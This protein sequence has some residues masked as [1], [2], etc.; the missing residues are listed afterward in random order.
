MTGCGRN[1]PCPCGSGKKYK[2]CCLA[3]NSGKS[4]AM[5]REEVRLQSALQGAIEHHQCG[6]LAEAEAGYRQILQAAPRHADALHL[7]GIVAQQRG[8]TEDAVRLIDSAIKA[9]PTQPVYYSNLGNILREQGR[10]VEATTLYRQALALQADL[11]D[12]H[13]SLAAALKDQGRLDEAAQSYCRAV[14]LKPG[15]AEAY[16]NLGTVFKEQGRFDQAGASYAQ[17]LSL[18]A[19]FAEVHYNLGN[20]LREQGSLARAGAS[21]ALAL[22]L[23]PDFAAVYCNL[24]T[25]L[26]DQGKLPEA[27]TAYAQA[28]LLK[29]DYADA[30]C[31]LGNVQRDQGQLDE[32]VASYRQA[33]WLQPA[34]LE[35]GNNLGNA[36]RQLGQFDEAI[37]VLL[38]A[39]RRAE[40]VDTKIAFAQGIKGLRLTG[41][42]PDI[43]TAVT[44]ALTEAWI[45]PAE[46][47]T[48]AMSLIRLD[49]DIGESIARAQSAWPRRLPA[50]EL[51][52]AQGLPALASELLLHSLLHSTPIRDLDF[53][54]FLTLARHALLEA[55]LDETGTMATGDAASNSL[56]EDSL[57]FYCALARQC[58]I[59]EYVF[60]LTDD[61][62]DKVE[63]LRS[64]LIEALA[65]RSPVP[66]LTLVA[67]AAYFPLHS[68]PQAHELQRLVWPD[69]VAAVLLQQLQEPAEEWQRRAR[70]PR[71]TPIGGSVSLQV[72]EQYEENPYPRWVKAPL[73]DK[74]KSV[75]VFLHHNFPASRFQAYGECSGVDILI[76]GC[77]TG[78]HAIKTA[79]QFS[80]ARLLAID[81]SLTSLCYAKRM[82]DALGLKNI[83]YAQADIMELGALGRSF[84]IIESVGVLHHLADPVAGW[85]VLLDLLRPGGF[86]DIG[87]YSALARRQ[88]VVARR[89][90]AE[91]GYAATAADIRRCRQDLMTLGGHEELLSFGDFFAMSDCRDLLFHVQEQR[92]TL[93]QLK[94]ILQTLGLGLVGFRL[95]ASVARQYAERFGSDPTRTD[96]DHWHQFET[97]HPRTFAAM[98]Q[99]WVQKPR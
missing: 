25:V 1:K 20:L 40:N 75:D 48:P 84:D 69:A 90:I 15:Y 56:T 78:Q 80:G 28:L 97:E 87:L 86:M 95:E 47:L 3:R 72:Q 5:K 83:E 54:R 37:S 74:P 22:A 94:D 77:G 6:R 41:A 14:S 60:A 98:Y 50:Q 30:H 63:R 27:A 64:R 36:L 29:P 39:L 18:Q 58:F 96:L 51:F 21:Y 19:D 49:P 8:N 68:L 53:E 31:N 92:Y 33:L 43:R 59:N 81:L 71:L 2:H 26:K 13:F 99:F 88:I 67:V 34:L 32:A 23:K 91:R 89:H 93:P 66:V 70:M 4:D 73:G 7:L 9:K 11:A 85:R 17:A 82:T 24:G 44:R 16:C 42:N 12:V 52:G 38:G 55:A 57:S 45:R 65:S 46:L 10:S 35:A 61:E 79:Q 76:A 62:A